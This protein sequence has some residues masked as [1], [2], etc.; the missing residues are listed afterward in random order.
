MRYEAKCQSGKFLL[1]L[2]V[3]SVGYEEQKREC[4][5]RIVL[6]LLVINDISEYKR[7]CSKHKTQ[8]AST[9]AAASIADSAYNTEL[10][11]F[12]CFQF[13]LRPVSTEASV[14]LRLP[15]A[16]AAAA[17][18]TAHGERSLPCPPLLRPFVL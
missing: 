14:K 4:S 1:N 6:R 18:A 11:A 15:L 8:A 5:S 17:D 9:A 3:S 13:L 12:F 16:V 2:Y 10:H 7:L